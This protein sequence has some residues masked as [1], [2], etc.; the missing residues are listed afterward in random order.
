MPVNGDIQYLQRHQLDDS[1][2]NRC[3]DAA[4][5]GLIYSY[6]H[7][8]DAM[9]D[10]WDAL[11]LGDYKA[12]MPLP[13]RKK[14]GV[15]YLYQPFLTA[16]LGLSGNGL[17]AEL[18]QQFFAAVPKKFRY[19]DISLN[20]GNLYPVEGY[21]LHMRS[22]YVLSL[23][24]SYQQLY[25]NYRENIRRNIKKSAGYGCVVTT[26]I[27]VERIITL[28]SQQAAQI[29]EADFQ[30]FV[31]LYNLLKEKGQAKTYGVLSG[32][33]E[34]LASCV[35]FFSQQR[36]F[37][38]LVG[39]HPNGRTLGASHALIDAFI[40]DHAGSDLLLD[41]EG[42][43]IRNLAFFYSSFGAVEEKYAAIKL[44]RLPWWMKWLK[45]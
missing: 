38:I 1:K 18:L 21:L 7:Y 29:P 13:W 42:S 30:N 39:N 11:V 44:N 27:E 24:A 6:T 10:N 35:F 33:D 16:Q 5:N 22:N 34:L 37:Y 12:V 32:S 3:L 23:S 36:A 4:P 15:H 25:K 2:W 31:R 40:K 20:H 43:D 41:F 26:G 45:K 19:W 9:C 17:N 28:A 8:L 14:G